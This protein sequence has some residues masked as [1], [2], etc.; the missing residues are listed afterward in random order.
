MASSA[1]NSVTPSIPATVPGAPTIGTAWASNAQATIIFTAPFSNGGSAVTGYK[2]TSSPG[3]ITGNG[4]VSPIRV[5][6]LTNGTAYSFTVIASN[7]IGG[8]LASAFSNSV[9]PIAPVT[10]IDGNIYNIVTIGAQVW[11]A[12]NLRTTKYN[13]GTAIPL[14]VSTDWQ[15]A[16]DNHGYIWYT[17]ADLAHGPLYKWST[18]S[19]ANNGGKNVCPISWHVPS[20]AEWTTLTTYLGGESV[21]GGKLKEADLIHWADITGVTNETGFTALAGGF[22]S[23]NG[24][25]NDMRFA[26]WWWSST[27]VSTSYAWIR[28]MYTYNN[29]VQRSDYGQKSDGYSVRCLRD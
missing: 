3:N 1:T 24:A 19:S 13:D 28:G 20:D 18:T 8:S 5:T 2:V 25:F 17:G 11:M 6:G 22:I 7:A 14:I 27:E 4:T 16:G 9:T 21:A 26:G 29:K 15:V 12:E 23:G 10:D